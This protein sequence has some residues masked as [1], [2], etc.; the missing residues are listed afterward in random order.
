MNLFICV[1]YH[2]SSR[3]ICPYDPGL[4]IFPSPSRKHPNYEICTVQLPRTSNT[5]TT[6]QD[7]HQHF[8][9]RSTGCT[10]CSSH[11]LRYLVVYCQVHV[12]TKNASSA[13]PEP[14]SRTSHPLCP[15]HPAT[16]QEIINQTRR[17]YINQRTSTNDIAKINIQPNLK[18]KL[19][20]PIKIKQ[21]QH[22]QTFFS[23]KDINKNN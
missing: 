1:W 11:Y 8:H 19:M 20:Q 12:W 15:E 18:S 7:Q 9:K 14:T 3:H 2:W 22:K 16:N 5:S 13:V 6:S 4:N 23:K 17:H 10:N 21:R